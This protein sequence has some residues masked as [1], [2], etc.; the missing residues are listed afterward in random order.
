M[1]FVVLAVQPNAFVNFRQ[2]RDHSL[3]QGL[4]KI[5]DAR[6]RRAKFP[7]IVDAFRP[8]AVLQITPEMILD[9][10]FARL[11][12]FA[13]KTYF[14]RSFD[15]TSAIFTAARA[16]SVPRLILCSRQRSRASVSLSKLRTALITGTP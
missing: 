11:S 1:E 9:R 2:M 7:E 4:R 6:R 14:P 3:D 16:A 5:A 12:P 13:H 15:I 8:L 10:G